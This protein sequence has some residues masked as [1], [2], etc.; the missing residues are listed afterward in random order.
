LRK[1]TGDVEVVGPVKIRPADLYVTHG[2]VQSGVVLIGDAFGTSCPAAGTG[3][4]KVFTDVERL[5]NVHI[6]NWF[7]SAGMGAGKIAA[8]YADPVKTA[9]DRQSFDKAFHLRSLSIDESLPWRARRWGRFL[10]RLVVSAARRSVAPQTSR[11]PNA[12][13]L[14]VGTRAG[15]ELTIPQR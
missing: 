1:F 4:N 10:G 8:F 7:A 14:P 6:P 11:A 2:H 13:T 5:C 15:T 3:T 12:T 9:C